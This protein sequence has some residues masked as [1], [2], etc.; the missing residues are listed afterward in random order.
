MA[1]ILAL[2][3]FEKLPLDVVVVLIDL[4]E[5]FLSIFFYDLGVILETEIRRELAVLE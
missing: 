5:S 2:K 4:I 1:V 3:F